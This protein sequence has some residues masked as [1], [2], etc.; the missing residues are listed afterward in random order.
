MIASPDNPISTPEVAKQTTSMMRKVMLLQG[1]Y[2]SIG[3]YVVN[4]VY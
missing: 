3:V 1:Y 4:A 2:F